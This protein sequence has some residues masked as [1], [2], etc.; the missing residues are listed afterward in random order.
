MAVC[1]SRVDPVAVGAALG[2]R[3][4]EGA[5]MDA[6]LRKL[7]CPTLVLRGEWK[8]GACVRDEDADWIHAAAPDRP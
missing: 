5:D 4:G 1:V 7:R 8:Y 6:A 2:D 3:M